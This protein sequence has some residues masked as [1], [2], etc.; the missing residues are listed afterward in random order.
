MK[1]VHSHPP[2]MVLLKNRNKIYYRIFPNKTYEKKNRTGT[3]QKC[4]LNI[5]ALLQ[6]RELQEWEIDERLISYF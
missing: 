5:A 6:Y 2:L 4:L 1:Q 3:R